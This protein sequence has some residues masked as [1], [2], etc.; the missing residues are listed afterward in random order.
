MG[1]R[2]I[3]LARI[4]TL[5]ENLNRA[6]NLGTTALTAAS[7]ILTTGDLRLDAGSIDIAD[8]VTVVQASNKTTG[9]TA[10]AF[11][12][13]ITM[14]G[15]ALADGVEAVFTVTNTKIA[16][17][18]I[19]IVNHASAGAAGSYMVHVVEVGAGSF[20]IG[21]GNVSGG[22]LSEAIVLHFAVI[23]MKHA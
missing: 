16:A 12:G 14:N 1:S 18:D 19:V 17:T 9:V 11:A 4:E 5:I 21:V 8:G 23:K 10:S 22:S 2:R 20:K 3:G 6:I 13:K 7:A 15:A